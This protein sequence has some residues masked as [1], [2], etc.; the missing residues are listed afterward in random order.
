MTKTV[1]IANLSNWDGED[2]EISI[3]RKGLSGRT[4]EKTITL[5]PG[6]HTIICHGDDARVDVTDV[7]RKEPGIMPFYVATREYNTEER[8]LQALAQTVPVMRIDWENT[9]N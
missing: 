4:E 6:D 1:V 8:H 3:K 5:K 2:F 9:K 7:E